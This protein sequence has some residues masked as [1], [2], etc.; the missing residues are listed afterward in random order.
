M[1]KSIIVALAFAAVL[2]IGSVCAVAHESTDTMGHHESGMHTGHGE[3]HFSRCETAKECEAVKEQLCE[4]TV[5][6]ECPD[7]SELNEEQKKDAPEAFF[8]GK[9]MGR[10]HGFSKDNMRSGCEASK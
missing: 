6:R 2:S 7:M 5:M 8:G 10:G 3:R 9:H 1:K 4:G